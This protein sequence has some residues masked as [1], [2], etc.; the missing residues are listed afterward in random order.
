MAKGF[1]EIPEH[2]GQEE[3]WE[4]SVE[5]L[6]LDPGE[7]KR[8][9]ML[10]LVT[11]A[12]R[13]WLTF[14]RRDKK[15][16]IV[17]SRDGEA[18]QTDKRFPLMC[19]DF[20]PETEKFTGDECPAHKVDL[21]AQRIFY[22]NVIDR[23]LQE[24]GERNPIRALQLPV[25]AIKHIK[26]ITKLEGID[27]LD[28]DDGYDLY[29][30]FD[31]DEDASS[32]WAIQKGDKAPLN[33][34]ERMW[35][36]KKL[37]D[38]DELV[39]FPSVEDVEE[40][41]KRCGYYELTEDEDYDEVDE[42]EEPSRS[43]KKKTATRG[44]SPAKAK[45]STTKKKRRP[46]RDEEED[47]EEEDED[48]EGEDEDF[49]EMDDEDQLDEDEEEEEE[50][51]RRKKRTT[52]KAT[53]RSKSKSRS[54]DDDED[55]DEEEDEPEEDEDEEDEDEEEDEPPRKKRRTARRGKRS[56]RRSSDDDD[57]EE[58]EEE[59]EE[60]EPEEDEEDEDE[61]EDEPPRKKRRTA[62]RGKSKRAAP[63]RKIRRVPAK[64]TKA[65]PDCMGHFNG[66]PPCIK[67]K[68]R[69]ACISESEDDE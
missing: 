40:S 26:G 22:V 17:F 56:S 29:V 10:G 3:K 68:V 9:R 25:T 52:K 4:D 47:E 7:F 30:K 49:D 34:R 36:R 62:S 31:P 50:P 24:N 18:Q 8:V 64:S 69:V 23:D 20:D 54:K 60:D 28:P 12:A 39:T 45:A 55:E 11:P 53:S 67:C 57:E 6:D 65:T 61:E 58:E 42:E 38:F 14:F 5:F 13:H 16:K 15:G 48:E 46:S 21:R 43:K 44:K 27:P 32:M 37:Y 1:L 33:K 66:S 59:E 35:L 2:K 51:P 41:I 19:L 63:K